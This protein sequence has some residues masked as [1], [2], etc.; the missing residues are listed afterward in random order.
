MSIDP[1]MNIKESNE[2]WHPD[3]FTHKE[4]IE[5]AKQYSFPYKKCAMSRT[6][7]HNRCIDYYFLPALMN[8]EEIFDVTLIPIPNVLKKNLFTNMLQTMQL[9]PFVNMK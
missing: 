1:V 7:H 3:Y 6:I 4:I 2:W 9:P 5:S 8:C